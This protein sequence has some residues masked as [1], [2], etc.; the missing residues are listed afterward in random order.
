MQ[1][2]L[3]HA[4]ERLIVS[5]D[6]LNS[7]LNGTGVALDHSGGATESDAVQYLL[8][9]V[10]SDG[11]VPSLSEISRETGTNRRQL[12]SDRWPQFRRC[13][14]KLMS[15]EVNLRK[16]QAAAFLAGRE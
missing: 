16:A 14:D 9:Q 12:R 13:Y 6:R 4:I 7:T 10:A 11:V 8:E 2:S 5:I 3:I 15:I 1:S